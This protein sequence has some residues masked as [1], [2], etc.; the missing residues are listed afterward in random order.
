[1]GRESKRWKDTEDEIQMQKMDRD[2]IREGIRQYAVSG[3]SR[4]R[5][6]LQ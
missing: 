6:R 1:M 2:R 4:K 3:E 5:G